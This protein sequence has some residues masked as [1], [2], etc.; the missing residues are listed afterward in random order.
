MRNPRFRSW[1]SEARPDGFPDAIDVA[2]SSDAA[3]QVAAVQHGRAD[4]VV[5]AGRLRRHRAA[6]RP[7]PRARARRRQPRAHG[8]LA[9]DQL[10]LPQ[11]AR[12]AVRRPA[13][14][15]GAQL[16]D[17]SPARG[18]ARGRRRPRGPDL[19]GDPARAARLRADAARTPATRR[20]AAAG[21]RRISPVP[22]GWSR[23]PARA[24]RACRCR[25]PRGTR[26]VIRY[27]GEVLRR[28]GYRVRVR[29]FPDVE[30]LLPLHQR[31][32]PPRPGG[33]RPGAPTS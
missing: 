19:P 28:L 9:D 5:A 21:R 27:A 3:A 10:A 12:A 22:A 30:Q 31:H 14:P 33:V 11:R 26:P 4:A 25:A 13:G 24:A 7:G 18:R 1:S 8:A 2:L 20:R 6:A 32:A 23:R 29:V 15:P 17:R 16:R